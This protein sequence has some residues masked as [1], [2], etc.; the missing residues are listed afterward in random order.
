MNDGLVRRQVNYCVEPLNPPFAMT[1]S[2]PIYRMRDVCLA[3]PLPADLTPEPFFSV[4]AIVNESR[5]FRVANL[6]FLHPEGGNYY[7]I[8]P[9]FV[10]EDE[11]R[12]LLL[13]DL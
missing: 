9:F 5:I 2:P 13:A 3:T 8:S 11:G 6:F 1:V 4:A 12:I 10:I 7:L